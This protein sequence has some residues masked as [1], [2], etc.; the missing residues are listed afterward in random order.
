MP[1]F[2]LDFNAPDAANRLPELF[3]NSVRKYKGRPS[4]ERGA[5]TV[6]HC[7]LEIQAM[8]GLGKGNWSEVLENRRQLNEKAGYEVMSTDVSE[9]QASDA[10]WAATRKSWN[11]FKD[12]AFS[13]KVIKY[14]EL[15]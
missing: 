9:L 14:S 5:A 7:S 12:G 15:G 4:E 2:A 8:D 3:A 10:E 1:G 11:D 13:L 6:L